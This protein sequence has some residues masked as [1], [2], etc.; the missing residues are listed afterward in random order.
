MQSFN[1]FIET[2]HDDLKLI[3]LKIDDF[4]DFDVHHIVHDV[5]QIV[6][7]NLIEIKYHLSFN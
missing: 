5:H 7:L 1:L 3:V 2:I 4:L 6:D